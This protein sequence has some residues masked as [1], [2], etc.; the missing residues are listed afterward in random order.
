MPGMSD[1]SSWR[2][3]FYV[4]LIAVAVS[5]AA[6]RILAA[7]RV[8]EPALHR[9]ENKPGD[10]RS[11]WPSK[12]PR[13]MPTFS[14]NDRSRWATVRALVDEGTYVV[15]MRN[16]RTVTLS[17]LVPLAAD[18]P[19]QAVVLAQSAFQAR[20][21]SKEGIVFEDGWQTI[22]LVLHPQVSSSSRA[23]RRCCRP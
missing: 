22:D 1:T 21:N 8:Y 7:A 23:S 10:Q 11:L 9:D 12:R 14:S 19:L 2:R 6:A 18:N 4:V 15:G 5:M 13:P 16:L 3:S 20:A 17:A